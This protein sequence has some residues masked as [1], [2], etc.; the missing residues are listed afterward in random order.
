MITALLAAVSTATSCAGTVLGGA[1][2]VPG[3]HLGP[4]CGYSPVAGVRTAVPP[5]PVRAE[6]TTG[7]VPLRLTTSQGD[8]VV[9]LNPATAPCAVHSLRYLADRGFYDRTRCH[10][11]AT[12]PRLQLVQCGDPTG[13]GSGGPG[14]RFADEL[15]GTERYARGTVAMANSGADTNGSQFF[16]VWGQADLPPVYTVVGVVRS[17]MVAIDTVAHGGVAPG[18]RSPLDGPPVVPLDLTRVRTT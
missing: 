3:A 2:T 18:G 13:T 9:D 11:L 14:Y 10:R 5:P 4:V 17:G 12:D 6:S 15:T 16:V 8:V 7:T 1:V